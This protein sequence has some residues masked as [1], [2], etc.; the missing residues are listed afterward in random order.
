MVIRNI[1]VAFVGLALLLAGCSACTRRASAPKATISTEDQIHSVLA[2]VGR[3]YAASDYDNIVALTWA[4]YL[5]QVDTPSPADVPPMA[6][7]P[8][9]VF[10]H[11]SPGA[12]A[13][14][15]GKE[16][17]GASADSLRRLAAALIR[18]DEASYIEAMSDVMAETMEVRIDK[19]EN[20]AI[21]GD[22]ATADASF[23]I[24]TGGKTNY[25]TDVTQFALVKEDGR[26]KD[27]TP[28]DQTE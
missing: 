26:W 20:L 17:A 9:E 27:C 28:P 25:T 21:N 15:L 2:R 24:G 23:V 3:A 1:G 8:L 12:L 7:L 13:E 22:N 10:S 4:K 14:R 18:K 16:Y 5:D 11:M 6:V 19:F